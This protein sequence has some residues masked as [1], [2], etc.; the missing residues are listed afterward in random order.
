MVYSIAAAR[1]NSF[2]CNWSLEVPVTPGFLG[3]KVFDDYPL[4]DLVGYIDWTPF[5]QTWELHGRF[6][7]ILEDEVVGEA[8]QNLFSDAQIMLTD[9]V[10]SGKLRARAVIGFWPA[11]SQGDDIIIYADSERNVE[12]TRLHM[13][14]QQG[15]KSGSRPN[16]CLADYI[17]PSDRGISDYIGGF[18]VSSGF[19]VEEIV[20]EFEAVHD[21]YSALMVKALADR[22]AE[23]FSERMHQRVRKEFWGYS[24]GEQLDND[25]LIKENY[26]G[27]RPAPGYPACPDHSEKEVLFNIL[28][29]EQ[30]T[31]ISLT[32]NFAMYPGASVSG[33]YFAHPESRYFG[34]GKI[35][36]DQLEDYSKRKKKPIS[37]MERWLG[38]NLNYQP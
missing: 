9:L 37:E 22:L 30:N 28:A 18:A 7:K 36:Q 3:T 1:K 27:I 26:R 17:A 19:G 23:A 13:L 34:V 8:A 15:R 25:G 10:Q 33:W 2:K 31:G 14:R 35:G 38:A 11:N 6:P 24:A 21:D 4:A 29:A 20:A 5:F 32:E 12:A 16:F